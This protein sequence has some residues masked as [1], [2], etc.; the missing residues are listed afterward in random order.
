VKLLSLAR[1]GLNSED[2]GHVAVLGAVYVALTGR[3][4]CL[5]S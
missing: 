1:L 2:A 5:G 3:G 4:A